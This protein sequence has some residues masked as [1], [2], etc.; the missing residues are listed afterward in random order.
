MDYDSQE[1]SSGD[2]LS[3]THRQRGV[4]PNNRPFQLTALL[5]ILILATLL[6]VGL[7]LFTGNMIGNRQ[8]VIDPGTTPTA[9]NDIVPAT[10]DKVAPVALSPKPSPE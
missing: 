3:S 5:A 7:W 6:A 4:E 10:E 1:S 2:S 9:V 8:T